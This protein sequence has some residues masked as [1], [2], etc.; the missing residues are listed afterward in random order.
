MNEA[1]T[2]YYQGDPLARFLLRSVK[3]TP[4]TMGVAAAVIPIL[5]SMGIA[6]LTGVLLPRPG[7]QALLTDVYFWFWGL[8][9]MPVAW[10]S[11]VWS[12]QV[13]KFLI[14]KIQASHAIAIATSEVDE[15][16]LQYVRPWRPWA[17]AAIAV[18]TGIL[19]FRSREALA[20]WDSS[21]ITTRLCSTF[22]WTTGMY[23]VCMLVLN[24]LTNV[25]ALARIFR[26][27]E[28]SVRPMAVDQA[29]G[30]GFLG[31]YAVKT[32]Y[33]AVVFGL[34]VFAGQFKFIA[35][36]AARE[37]WTVFLE[38]VAYIPL[39]IVLFFAPLR[40]VHSGMKRTRDGW[41]EAIAKEF[42]AKYRLAY[43]Q[44][45]D[46]EAFMRRVERLKALQDL[47]EMTNSYPTWP[48]NT[49]T[50]RKFVT[51]VVTPLLAFIAGSAVQ[52]L[53]ALVS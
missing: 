53:S 37:N 33:I 48:Y 36:G 8:V 38:I 35:Q 1:M 47:F 45:G 49:N 26:N 4:V 27:K 2:P 25:W 32:V 23:A 39:T 28:I 51:S 41:L 29:G 40:T 15:I 46:T 5:A 31:E 50:I 14:Q 3:L 12:A 22:F 24:L 7:I 19:F 16:R 9:I 44:L 17:A 34:G 52:I 20:G 11:Y 10:G 21:T 42:E 30:L 43:E 18:F 13:I 6:L